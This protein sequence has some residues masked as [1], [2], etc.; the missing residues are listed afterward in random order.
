MPCRVGF[1]VP[2]LDPGG[3]GSESRKI[4]LLSISKLFVYCY[5]SDI[6]FTKCG[7]VLN[8]FLR[9]LKK[10]KQ[11]GLQNN[12]WKHLKDNLKI[13]C[14][15][16]Y[17]FNFQG[18]STLWL[19]L[20]SLTVCHLISKLCQKHYK[21]LVRKTFFKCSL[22]IW[23]RRKQVPKYRIMW[24][25]IQLSKSNILLKIKTQM[26]SE[27]F[28]LYSWK[29]LHY[30]SWLSFVNRGHFSF[31]V[32]V[33]FRKFLSHWRCFMLPKLGVGSLWLLDVLTLSLILA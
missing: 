28:L 16:H 4:P 6:N 7:Q 13:L 14:H 11:Y 30:L 8:H 22:P 9:Q 23:E 20:R 10:K 31:Q 2:G 15:P 18:C 27:R 21:A 5:H 24:N 32:F 1:S 25:S 17:F 33:N 12:V 29:I 3:P 26:P 19:I